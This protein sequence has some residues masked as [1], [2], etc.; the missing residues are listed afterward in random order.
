MDKFVPQFRQVALP[1]PPPVYVTKEIAYVI[2]RCPSLVN[3]IE[4]IV[5]YRAEV[6]AEIGTQEWVHEYVYK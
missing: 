1:P 3:G 5:E 4:Q 2:M 6:G